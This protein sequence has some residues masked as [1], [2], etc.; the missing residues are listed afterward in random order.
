METQTNYWKLSTIILGLIVF[1]QVVNATDLSSTRSLIG[2]RSDAEQ[3]AAAV[4]PEKGVALPIRWG[5]LGKRMTD[6]GVID[7]DAFEKL[8]AGRG[9]LS[10]QG[11]AMLGEDYQKPIIIN[12]ENAGELLNLLWAFGLANTSPILKDETE[13]MNPAYGGAGNF[14]STGGWTLAEGDAMQ[15]Y[16]AHTF[17]QLTSEQH[18]LVERVSE[19]IYRPCCGNST[20]F[21]DCNHGMAMLGLLE[22]LAA[23]GAS[24]E[25][26]YQVALAVNSYWFPD[27][28]LTIGQ[29]FAEQGTDWADADPKELLGYD[30]S[31]AA[32]YQRITSLVQPVEQNGGGGCSA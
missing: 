27:T 15:H 26:M 18:A 9:S 3:L 25:D 12:R 32:G 20:H 31:S 29:Y 23:N 16:N 22:L 5:D 8:Y 4:I 28:Y 19:G 11:Q 1:V 17:V 14:A 24:E 21:P 2:G 10:D 30:Y 6:A 7:K 13:M